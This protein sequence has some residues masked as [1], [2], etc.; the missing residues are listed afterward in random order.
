MVASEVWPWI[1]LSC[2]FLVGVV[3]M[4]LPLLSMIS[5]PKRSAPPKTSASLSALDVWRTEIDT[6]IAELSSR[7][8][9]LSSTLRRL[10]ARE[11]MRSNRQSQSRAVSDL[12][13]AELKA[14]LRER[15]GIVPGPKVNG[16]D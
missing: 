16:A 1:L 7:V 8:D 2:L 11:S 12:S 6:Q 15:Y 10:G 14:A 4:S 13:P 5:T 9:G 3:A